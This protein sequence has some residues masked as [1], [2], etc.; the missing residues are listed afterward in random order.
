MV[1]FNIANNNNEIPIN[2][3]EIKLHD[4]IKDMLLEAQKDTLFS[5]ETDTTLEFLQPFRR[6][7]V[8][9]VDYEYQP[10]REKVL[11]AIE[12]EKEQCISEERNIVT[13]LEYT[14]LTLLHIGKV[15][16]ESDFL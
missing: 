13:S 7:S 1:T 3:N 15:G 4:V 5:L 6:Y 2:K 12:T 9:F 11:E 10:T 14:K 16:R 8:N